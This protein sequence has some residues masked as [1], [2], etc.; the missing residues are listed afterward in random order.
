MIPVLFRIRVEREDRRPFRLWLPLFIVWLVLIPLIIA[1]SPFVLLAVA[2]M[3]GRWYKMLFLSLYPI[4][5][6]C[7]WA[8][9]GLSM[10]LENRKSKIS[11]ALI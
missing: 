6:S 4:L 5:F 11:I 7:L 1:L 2:A 3:R 9:S 8:L 10:Q